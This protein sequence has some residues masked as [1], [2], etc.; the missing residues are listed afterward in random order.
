M[1]HRAVDVVERKEEADQIRYG[2]TQ[3]MKILKRWDCTV[4]RR[5]VRCG[6]S[7]Q[8]EDSRRQ[9]ERDE[10]SLSEM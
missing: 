5:K 4:E 9:R 2:K 10:L 8:V 3:R 6:K 1:S 7:Y